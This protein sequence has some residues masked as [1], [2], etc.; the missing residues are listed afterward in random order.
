MR[1]SSCSTPRDVAQAHRGGGRGPGGP[2]LRDTLAERGHA[3]TLFERAHEIG[4]QFRYAREVPGKEEFH[5]TLRYFAR[6]HRARGVTL[7]LNTPRRAQRSR[8]ADSTR[9]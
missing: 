3:V 4:G 1:P 6:Q 8:A 7:R 2:G 9:S 5:D